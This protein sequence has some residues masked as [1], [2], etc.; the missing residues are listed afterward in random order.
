[1]GH[2]EVL[3]AVIR[4]FG[5]SRDLLLQFCQVFQQ[6]LQQ[7][8]S[9]K[10]SMPLLECL[11]AMELDLEMSAAPLGSDYPDAP[12][13]LNLPELE[14]QLCDTGLFDTL[15]LAQL[16]DPLE[17]S[18]QVLKNQLPII[19]QLADG[20]PSPD[21]PL[22]DFIMST[23]CTIAD[24]PS[25][26]VPAPSCSPIESSIQESQ[27]VGFSPILGRKRA[28]ILEKSVEPTLK[29]Q[30]ATHSPIYSSKYTGFQCENIY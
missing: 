24:L 8:L 4:F 6:V 18:L 14:R 23:Q 15:S 10:L 20:L 25:Q 16:S 19:K 5:R 26:R 13:K 29:M 7:E 28:R 17:K 11:K 2:K 1:M 30:Q 9:P 27:T 3:R 21:I 22:L 12:L